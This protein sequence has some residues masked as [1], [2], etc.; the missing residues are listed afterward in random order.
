MISPPSQHDIPTLTRPQVPPQA[1]PPLVPPPVLPPVP[2]AEQRAE[3]RAVRQ[4]VA[5]EVPVEEA[6]PQVAPS[7]YW[8]LGRNASPLVGGSGCPP[9]VCRHTSPLPLCHEHHIH[10]PHTLLLSCPVRWHTQSGQ[11]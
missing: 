3:Q 8:C 5:Q 2:R 1:P 7:P 10:T 4:E 6:Q 11:P 9:A